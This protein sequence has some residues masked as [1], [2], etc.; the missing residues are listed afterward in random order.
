MKYLLVLQFPEDRFEDIESIVNIEEQIINILGSAAAVDG[1]DYGSDQVNVF[2][3]AS[4]PEITFE[5]TKQVLANAGLL[6]ATTAA[7]REA[8]GE[9][10]I[11][12]WPEG[13]KQ[14]F[15]IK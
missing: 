10:Y 1:H 6:K 13:A 5:K 15:K 11:V 7:Y 8:D 3:Y 2:I 4:E 12:I 14:N 9:K